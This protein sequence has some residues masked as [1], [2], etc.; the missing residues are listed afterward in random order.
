LALPALLS[1]TLAAAGLAN[2]GLWVLFGHHDRLA[3]LV[4]PQLGLVPA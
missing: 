3:F 4:H 1:S 2:F